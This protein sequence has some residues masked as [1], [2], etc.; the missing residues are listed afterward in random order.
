MDELERLCETAGLVVLGRDMQSMQNP[1]PSTFIGAGKVEQVARKLKRLGNVAFVVFDDELSPAQGRNLQKA[2][3]GEDGKSEV[4]VLDRTQLIL[5][6]F[7][8]RARTKEAKLQVGNPHTPCSRAWAEA[9][10]P[11]VR[12][13]KQLRCGTSCHG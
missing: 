7:A 6:I 11:C 5:Q 8:Q 1:S 2:W 12:R 4:V 9:D 13:C 3:G 10:A